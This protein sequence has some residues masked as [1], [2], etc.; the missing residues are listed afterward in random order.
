MGEMGLDLA[1]GK[2]LAK[3]TANNSQHDTAANQV[4]KT[5]PLQKGGF[6]LWEIS[7]G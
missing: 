3:S 5:A 6:L 1:R 4:P 2:E 7:L